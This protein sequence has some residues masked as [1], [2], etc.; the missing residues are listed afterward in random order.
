MLVCE[1]EKMLEKYFIELNKTSLFN[2]W[3]NEEIKKNNS[4]AMCFLAKLCNIEK[5]I[6]DTNCTDDLN[7]SFYSKY[8]ERELYEMSAKMDNSTAYYKLSLSEYDRGKKIKLLEKCANLNNINACYDLG[9]MYR[10]GFLTNIDYSKA[11]SYFKRG[12]ELGDDDKCHLQLSKMYI[13]GEGVDMDLIKGLEMIRDNHDYELYNYCGN[14]SVK[15]MELLVNQKNEILELKQKINKLE[16]ENDELKIMAPIE[17][18]PEFQK[19]KNRFENNKS[20]LTGYL[21]NT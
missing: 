17:G 10:K 2:D 1:V 18:G 21:D 16:S 14:Y 8:N 12:V 6:N 19:A 15:I 4:Y 5:K 11:F 3:L 20:K 9:Y 7:H 13:N